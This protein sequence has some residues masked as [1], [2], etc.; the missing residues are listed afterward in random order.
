MSGLLELVM[1]P[2]RLQTNYQPIVR[3]GSTNYPVAFVECLIR[4]PKGTNLEVPDVLFEYSR[5]KHVEA[6][7]DMVA[8]RC[9]LSEMKWLC[10]LPFSVNFHA[11][12]LSLDRM[13]ASRIIG[14][15]QEAGIFPHRLYVEV[16]E[17]VPELN[18]DHF[19]F[20]LSVLKQAGCTILL[21]DFGNGYSNLNLLRYIRP[22]I[23]KIDRGLLPY[24][25]RDEHAVA[26]FN[27]AI[28][29]AQTVTA[30]VLVEGIETSQQLQASEDLRIDYAQGFYFSKPVSA[31]EVQD[32]LWSLTDQAS[33][34]SSRSKSA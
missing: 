28:K 14:E 11:S 30:E 33:D 24:N 32:W 12:T 4:G 6:S 22:D 19:L 17:T 29:C 13:A 34:V 9:F 31:V 27:A 26:C 15:L 21:D 16:I 2:R 5:R 10:R 3:C 18:L 8:L 7:L 23:V 1:D 25:F 20:N